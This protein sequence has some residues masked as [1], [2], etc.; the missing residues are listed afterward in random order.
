MQRLRSKR[1]TKQHLWNF[2]VNPTWV[3][4]GLPSWAF[5]KNLPVTC[6]WISVCSCLQKWHLLCNWEHHAACV[7]VQLCWH[8]ETVLSNLSHRGKESDIRV[9]IS[10]WLQQDRQTDRVAQGERTSAL[11]AG[12]KLLQIILFSTLHSVTCFNHFVHRLALL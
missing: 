12:F 5:E 9:S 7:R 1:A 11:Y 10:K 2:L 3:A 8:G 4:T 6:G